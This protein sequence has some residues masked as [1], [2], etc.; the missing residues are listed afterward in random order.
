TASQA[1]LILSF[2][3]WKESLPPSFVRL[4][5]GLIV[6]RN[7]V[8]TGLITRS[9]MKFQAFLIESRIRLK[10]DLRASITERTSGQAV[11][12]NHWATAWIASLI[13]RQTGCAMS[14]QPSKLIWSQPMTMR[15]SGHP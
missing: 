2:I 5:R 12:L 6:S 11:F 14:C 13:G 1:F 7:H 3:E 4:N 9:L 8:A 15:T 10:P